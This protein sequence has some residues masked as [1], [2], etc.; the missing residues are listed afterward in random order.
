M[1]TARRNP[2][3]A[4]FVSDRRY[5][6][7]RLAV[8]DYTVAGPCAECGT[9]TLTRFVAPESWVRDQIQRAAV[10]CYG[11][12]RKRNISTEAMQ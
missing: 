7:T 9:R 1:T 12:H 8:D 11:C 3:P 2:T 5:T 6:V 10:V 4:E